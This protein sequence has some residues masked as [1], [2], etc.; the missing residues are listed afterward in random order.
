M[1]VTVLVAMV[2]AVG[3][4][5]PASAEAP[6]QPTETV[7]RDVDGLPVAK[8]MMAAGQATPSAAV[9]T[10]IPFSM[11]AFTVPE[12]ASVEFRT[13]ADGRTWAEWA[14]AEP[15]PGE[16]PDA[17]SQDAELAHPTDGVP[18]EPL[19][20]GEARWVQ[21]R[22]SGG[23]P[24][25]VKTHLVDSMGLSRSLIERARDAVAAAWNATTPTVAHAAPGTPQIVSRAQWG[26]NEK[27]RSG[28]PAS[29]S[30]P[31]FAVF[32]HTAGT[33]NYSRA[34][35]P[36]IVRGIYYY[37]AVTRGWS[38]VGYNFLVDRYGT[39]YEGRAGGVEKAVIGA[40]VGGFNTGSIGVSV[41]GNFDTGQLPTA[42]KE[43]VA[44]LLAWK[45][46]LHHIDVEGS[47]KV[48]SRCRSNCKIPDGK[49]VTMPTLVGHRDLGRTSCPGKNGYVQLPWLRDRIEQLQGDVLVNPSASPA[50][51]N[52]LEDG[53][54]ERA[55]EF[56][57]RLKPA[58]EWALEIRSNDGDVVHSESGS[59]STAKVTWQSDDLSSGTYWWVFTS[60]GRTRA[61]G[62]FRLVE[63][64]Y[65]R[66]AYVSPSTAQ[67]DARGFTEPITV[68]VRLQPPGKWDLELRTNDGDVVLHKTGSGEEAEVRWAGNGRLEPG[69]YWYVFTSPD[70]ERATGTFDVER[71]PFDPPFWDDDYSVHEPGIADLAEHGITKG[72]ADGRF[73]PSSDVTRG[74]MA[75]FFARTLSHM[76]RSPGSSTVDYFDDDN[77]NVHESAINALAR[78]G[79]TSGCQEAQFCPT[80]PMT[81]NQIAAWLVTGFELEPSGTDHFDDDDGS[82]YEEAINAL[83]DH[84]LTTGCA[85]DRYCG[86][87]TT[88]R[89]QMATF[90]ARAIGL[91]PRR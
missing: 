61:L 74:Q 44:R 77:G 15:L 49:S 67:V 2:V 48:T 17:G 33:N 60:P 50:S 63:A 6:P 25:D 7:G 76:G 81:R 3:M 21:T 79:V 16:G 22:V 28:S 82:A 78:I 9:E 86:G 45:L 37:H 40:H 62:S 71:A 26:A 80:A 51:V 85:P 29:V 4:P 56:G 24:Q 36:G 41:M 89:A 69:L 90:L 1:L 70:R 10:P 83:A 18:T 30:Q 65:L 88:S 13:S 73:C 20:V 32:H 47:V 35:A 5:L 34:E 57:I 27:Y 39:I 42:A 84:G 43:S 31:R 54:M 58:G 12:G 66:D 38:D 64:L 59:G 72:C 11:I 53:G 23:S 68:G 91:L 8:E 46:D 14:E 19:W 52:I 87:D 55:I 75:S